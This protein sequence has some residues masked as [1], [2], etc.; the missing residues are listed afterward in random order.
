[1]PRPAPARGAREA[2]YR[3]L[4]AL[5]RAVLRPV[6]LR[7]LFRAPVRRVDLRALVLRAVLLR[8]V[9]RAAVLRPGLVP[10][11]LRVAAAF[12]AERD[13]AAFERLA[14]AAP[15]LRPPF[16]AGALF[17][18][19]PRPE[20]DLLPPPSEALTVAHARLS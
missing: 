15:P 17:V 4:R 3:D 13:F 10:R 9:L 20:P 7:A 8:A 1:I 19:L 18:A 14:E 12:L 2:N 5:L 11:R 6:L 16:F